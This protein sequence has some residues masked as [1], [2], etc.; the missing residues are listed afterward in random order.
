M[1]TVCNHFGSIAVTIGSALWDKGIVTPTGKYVYNRRHPGILETLK[2]GTEFIVELYS[3]MAIRPIRVNAV[4]PHRFSIAHQTSS[5]RAGENAQNSVVNS[6]FES[7]DV[8]NLFV[9]SAAV[10]PRGCLSF[11]HIPVSVV[12]AYTWRRMV[13]NHFSR[14]A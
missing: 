11:S 10:I 12:A 6:D 4:P 8:E 2:E 7:H 14:G 9:S 5:C 3:K 1:K 13:E